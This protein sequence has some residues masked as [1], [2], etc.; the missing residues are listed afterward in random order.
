MVLEC[1][2]CGFSLCS[3]LKRIFRRDVLRSLYRN[4]SPVDSFLVHF[5]LCY[6]PPVFQMDGTNLR[7]PSCSIH[8]HPLPQ[9]R[10][11]IGTLAQTATL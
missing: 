7:N 10:A 9:Q 4:V 1:H 11:A 3:F 8:S 2:C 6:F 5:L